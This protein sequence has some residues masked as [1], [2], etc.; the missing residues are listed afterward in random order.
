[1]AAGLSVPLFSIDA[2][3]FSM[4]AGLVGPVTAAGLRFEKLCQN[5]RIGPATKIEEYVPTIIPTTRANANPS[6]TGPPKIHKD[7]AV[8]NVRPEVKTVRLNV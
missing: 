5:Y 1:M 8:R 7:N 3:G 4:L 6:R 2:P